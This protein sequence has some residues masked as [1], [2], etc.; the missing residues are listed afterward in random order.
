[1]LSRARLPEQLERT[2]D[3]KVV[4]HV[5]RNSIDMNVA[6]MESGVRSEGYRMGEMEGGT[7]GGMEWAYGVGVYG[8]GGWSWGME[9]LKIIL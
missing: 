1:M 5:A 4:G 9:W 8:V 6:G 7:E 3:C 2:G